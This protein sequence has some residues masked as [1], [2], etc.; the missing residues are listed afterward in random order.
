[1]IAPDAVLDVPL[2]ALPA[3]E[4]ALPTALATGGLE[5]DSPDATD[6]AT[7][8][9]VEPR[10]WPALE[11]TWETVPDALWITGGAGGRGPF[12]F[13]LPLPPPPLDSPGAPGPA[14]PL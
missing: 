3:A 4:P 14:D 9:T 2:T 12:P 11:T 8:L 7:P 1:L 6:P 5:P 13:P 10:F